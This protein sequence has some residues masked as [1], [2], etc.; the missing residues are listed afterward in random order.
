[1]IG[2]DEHDGRSRD[3]APAEEAMASGPPPASFPPAKPQPGGRRLGGP[4]VA[5]A[6]LAAVVV[7]SVIAVVTLGDAPTH[8]RAAALPEASSAASASPVA[9]VKAPRAVKARSTASSVLLTW[10]SA[11]G[12]EGY[13]IRILRDGS[14]VARE[15]ADARRFVDEDLAP[16]TGYTYLLQTHTSDGRASDDVEVSARTETPPISAARLADVF[17]V[18]LKLESSYGFSDLPGSQTAGWRFRPGCGTGAC[19]VTLSDTYGGGMKALELERD[20]G[21]YTGSGSGRV[22][23]ECRGTPTTSGYTVELRVVKAAVINGVWR[24]TKLEGT[25]RITNAPQLGCRSGGITMSLTATQVPR[26]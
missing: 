9:P 2:S 15:P 3:R 24:A 26:N 4:I 16:G 23:Y 7:G 1:M 6:V 19:D 11:E 13:E 17:D 5:L 25:H 12:G 8:D 20:G 18:R 10:K 21:R 22:G 14:E